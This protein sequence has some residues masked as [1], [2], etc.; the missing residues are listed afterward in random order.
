MEGPVFLYLRQ[1]FFDGLRPSLLDDV[2]EDSKF[3]IILCG[4]SQVMQAVTSGFELAGNLV[5]MQLW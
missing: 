3:V 1:N 4:Y 2:L 5:N